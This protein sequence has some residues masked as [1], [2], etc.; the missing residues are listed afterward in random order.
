MRT[1]FASVALLTVALCA[2]PASAHKVERSTAERYC[3]FNVPQE[4]RFHGDRS[5]LYCSAQEFEAYIQYAAATP[6]NHW[7]VVLVDTATGEVLFAR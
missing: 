6:A 3:V 4:D 7:S 1:F 2:M 5:V